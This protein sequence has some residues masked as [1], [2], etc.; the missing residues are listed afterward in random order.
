MNAPLKTP[1]SEGPLG[2]VLQPGPQNP[3]AEGISGLLQPVPYASYK[4]CSNQGTTGGRL[5]T[6][7]PKTVNTRNNQMVRGKCKTINNRS[8]YILTPSEPNFTT[9]ASPGYTSTPKNQ[10]VD[11]KFYLMR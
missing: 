2:G 5:Q 6:E 11:L 4:T 10:D 1:Q 7:T 3:Q 9:T 8:Q